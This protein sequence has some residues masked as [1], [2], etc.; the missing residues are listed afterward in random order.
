MRIMRR[1]ALFSLLLLISTAAIAQST[2]GKI[3]GDVADNTGAI[4][5]SASVEIRDVHTGLTQKVNTNNSGEF[6]FNLVQPGDYAVT[7]TAHPR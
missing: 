1:I 5:P 4:L 7:A 3:Y 6:T 2:T